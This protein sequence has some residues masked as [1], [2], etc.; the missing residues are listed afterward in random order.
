MEEWYLASLITRRSG[1]DFRSRN[2]FL[3]DPGRIEL[4]STPFNTKRLRAYP[5]LTAIGNRWFPKWV[6]DT[7]TTPFPSE[8][9]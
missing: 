1:F 9:R 3:V 8:G 5:I 7:S 4:P 2:K 6:Y